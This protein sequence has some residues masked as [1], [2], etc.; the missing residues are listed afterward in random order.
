MASAPSTED[1]GG[2]AVEVFARL[3][4]T[5]DKASDIHVVERFGKQKSVQCHSDIAKKDLEFT[6]DWIFTSEETQEE[7][8][9]KA[10]E[11]R[12]AAVLEGFNATL[13]CYGQTGA[14]KTH[15]MFGPDEVITDFDSCDPA[16]WGIVP[17]ATEQIF[18][19]LAATADTSTFE[20]ECS[21]L[22]VYNDHLKCLLGGADNMIIHEAK[23][24]VMVD[25][26]TKRPVDSSKAIMEQL[27]VGNQ[28]R[29]VAPMKMNA[30]SSR[31]HGVFTVYIK[32]ITAAGN[33]SGK[34]NL[35]DLAGMESSKKS[36]P[37][38]GASNTPI[39]R[40]EAKQI[41]VGRNQQHSGSML[42]LMP[43][44]RPHRLL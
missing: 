16:D 4:P 27:N 21:Y 19:G 40:E 30:R 15:T 33:R 13:L 1:A 41:N 29:V 7:V 32:E 20:V 28:R 9:S 5:K 35:V 36:Y 14:G 34:L 31:G 23:G 38:E 6:L 26:L 17:R 43:R 39:R 12:V 22:E 37:V 8:Y 2:E 25:G 18:R 11:S 10:G 42:Q 3:K 24:G 44:E